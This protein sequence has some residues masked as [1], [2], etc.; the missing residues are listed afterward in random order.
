LWG[1]LILEI[2]EK[3]QDKHE[4]IQELE[5]RNVTIEKK[6]VYDFLDELSRMF[7]DNE[8]TFEQRKEI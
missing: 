5:K 1:G 6:Y 7:S 8:T 4:I 2:L 3:A